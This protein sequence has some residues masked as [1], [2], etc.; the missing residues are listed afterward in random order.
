MVLMNTARIVRLCLVVALC[1]S[2][3][4]LGMMSGHEPAGTLATGAETASSM[5]DHHGHAHGEDL[6]AAGHEAKHM[7]DHSH[8]TP[9]A[10]FAMAYVPGPVPPLD[11]RFMEPEFSDAPPSPGDKPPRIPG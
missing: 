6:P 5:H 8:D 11:I 3:A 2:V 9:H 10:G 4:S 7:A 1:L